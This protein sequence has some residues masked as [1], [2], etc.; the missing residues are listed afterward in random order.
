MIT[1]KFILITG[2]VVWAIG[3]CITLLKIIVEIIYQY[4]H[5][6][7]NGWHKCHQCKQLHATVFYHDTFWYGRIYHCAKHLNKE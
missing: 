7:P 3:F 2:M 6:A 5:T 1:E 4:Q